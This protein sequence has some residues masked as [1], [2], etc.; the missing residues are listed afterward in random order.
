[1]NVLLADQ[2]SHTRLGLE[3]L[4]TR[5]PGVHIVGTA[6]EAASLLALVRT[7]QADLI[8]MDEALPG[9]SSAELI[10]LLRAENPDARIILLRN[11][12]TGEADPDAGQDALVSKSQAPDALLAAFRALSQVQDLS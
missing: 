1:M 5:E 3:M 7:T 8:V 4:L 2:Y 10:S 6:G 11:A 12:S 9:G